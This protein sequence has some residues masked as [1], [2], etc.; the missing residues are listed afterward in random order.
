MVAA[1][2]KW[3]STPSYS[4]LFDDRL[5]P[6]QPFDDL[7]RLETLSLEHNSLTQLPEGVF[8]QLKHLRRLELS[9]NGLTTLDGGV[10]DELTRLTALYLDQ[11][12]L[13]ILPADPF[14]GLRHLQYV[15]L[16][17]NQLTELPDGV[18]AGLTSLVE[19]RLNDN[20]GADFTLTAELERATDGSVSVVIAEGAPFP[21]QVGLTATVGILTASAQSTPVPSPAA[22]SGSRRRPTGKV[23]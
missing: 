10:F 5:H 4:W 9:S 22:R 12:H 11:N 20:P 15:E 18:F 21:V 8:D 23:R 17:H 19:L 2:R 16:S 3:L 7:T 1:D 13:T 6:R 14:D